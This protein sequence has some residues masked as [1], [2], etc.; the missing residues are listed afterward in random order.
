[1]DRSSRPYSLA[2]CPRD[3]GVLR[4]YLCESRSLPLASSVWASVP[5]SMWEAELVVG[6]VAGAAATRGLW[7]NRA[8][9][10]MF[11]LA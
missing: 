8:T 11:G 10:V 6:R 4:I 2:H 5:N 9:F 7:G 3:S 1:H